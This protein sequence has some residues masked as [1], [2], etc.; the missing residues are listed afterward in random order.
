VSSGGLASDATIFAG[1][2]VVGNKGRTI[3]TIVS[4]G[5][6]LWVSSGGNASGTIVLNGGTALVSDAGKASGTTILT[7]GYERRRVALAIAAARDVGAA[8]RE[9]RRAR[10][11]MPRGK[12][13]KSTAH[14]ARA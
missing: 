12:R 6:T 11:G 5:G 9:G 4:S 13:M 3:G 7:G 14:R 1:S 10:R 8:Q 2:Q